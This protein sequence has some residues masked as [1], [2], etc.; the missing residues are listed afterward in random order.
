MTLAI[1]DP[2][3]MM[4]ALKLSALE[5]SFTHFAG[6]SHESTIWIMSWCQNFHGIMMGTS[7][8]MLLSRSRRSLAFCGT[9]GPR[10]DLPK[11]P[12]S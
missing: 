5:C 12:I 10:L 11:W 2:P 6:M 1:V 8:K 3:A 7:R 4:I 9:A